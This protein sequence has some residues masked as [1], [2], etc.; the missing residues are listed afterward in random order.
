M[1]KKSL[2]SSLGSS[3]NTLGSVMEGVDFVRKAWGSFN[4]PSNFAPTVDV[5]ELEKRITDLKAI[6][7]WLDL[8]VKMLRGSIQA[9]E[10]QRSTIAAVKAMG[11]SLAPDAKSKMIDPMKAIAEAL[12]ADPSGATAKAFPASIV[13]P[14]LWWTTLQNQFGE[15]AAAALATP[16]KLGQSATAVAKSFGKTPTASATGK[17]AARK[18]TPKSTP[19]PTRSPTPKPAE[20][21]TRKPTR[22]PA[23]N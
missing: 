22:K 8:N 19:S 17:K 16:S 4:L 9:L 5:A 7:Q 6:E 21:A 15:I 3:L 1:T 20:R 18:L 11:Q 13:N 10:V 14:Q 12:A 2:S 23:S